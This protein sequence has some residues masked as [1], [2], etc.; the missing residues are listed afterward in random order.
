MVVTQ[1][2]PL[3]YTQTE[4][5]KIEAHVPIKNLIRLVSR[6]VTEVISHLPN[7]VIAH[8][9]CH[10]R[11]HLQNPLE[12]ASILQDGPLTVSQIMQQSMSKASACQT[13]TGDENIPAEVIHLA[14]TLLFSG[15]QGVVATMW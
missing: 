13:A 14:S 2:G 3:L 1:P 9:A 7:T 12:S 15:F 10:G 11:Q 4:L 6:T 8:F 5:Q